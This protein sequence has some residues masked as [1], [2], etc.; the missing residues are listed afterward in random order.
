MKSITAQSSEIQPLLENEYI[1]EEYHSKILKKTES[2]VKKT[3]VIMLLGVLL[4][5]SRL[6]VW[7]LYAKSLK[8]N[9][10]KYDYLITNTNL[11]ILLFVNFICQAIG[12]ILWGFLADQFTYEI[13]YLAITVSVVIFCTIEALA[14]NFIMLSC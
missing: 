7:I 12:G 3:G 14:Q 9:N 10:T 2:I 5:T 8:N 11:T 13:I 6:Y 4:S 1:D